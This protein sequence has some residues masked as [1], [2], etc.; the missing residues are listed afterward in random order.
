MENQFTFKAFDSYTDVHVCLLDASKAFDR[1]CFN[2]LYI[3]V[4]IGLKVSS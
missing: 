1:L 3:S 4:V 2:K